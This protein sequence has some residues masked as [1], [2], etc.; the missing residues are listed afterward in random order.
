MITKIFNNKHYYEKQIKL[1]SHNITTCIK[2]YNKK[3][4]LTI[5]TIDN[6][7]STNLY[8]KNKIK[9]CNITN[10]E[11]IIFKLSNSIK[12]NTII[13]IINIINKDK[14]INGIIIQLPLPNKLKK[15]YIFLSIN[16][17]KDIDLLNPKNIGQ[18]INGYEKNIIPCTVNAVK[19]T[20]IYLKIKTKGLNACIIGFS[21][22]VGKPLIYQLYS[23]G[24]TPTIINQHNKQF[25]KLIKYNDIIIIA[26]GK[27]KYVK[28][29]ELPIG[30]L[31]IDIGINNYKN[32]LTIGDI[33]LKKNNKQLS[34]ITPVPNGIGLLTTLNL[35]LNNFKLFLFQNKIK[36]K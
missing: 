36:L 21:N 31:A 20:L 30:G 7:F 14:N 16:K 32:K 18:Y 12:T 5:I 1:L 4:K 35:L 10:T 29:N 34:Y 28:Q 3:P 6:Y 27:K 25:K 9:S 11:N 8:I 22:I 33:E 26:L 19:Q 24:I 17:K 15:K 23:M 13:Q 2:I